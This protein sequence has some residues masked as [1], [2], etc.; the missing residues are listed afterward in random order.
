M[1]GLSSGKNG[2]RRK[3]Y[4]FLGPRRARR[5]GQFRS[6]TAALDQQCTKDSDKYSGPKSLAQTLRLDAQRIMSES[7]GKFVPEKVKESGVIYP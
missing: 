7:R 6:R 1:P 2:K 4:T 3:G 5:C